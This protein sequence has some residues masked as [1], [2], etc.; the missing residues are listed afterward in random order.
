MIKLKCFILQTELN[1]FLLT[2][3][4]TFILKI[5]GCLM[6]Y[7]VGWFAQSRPWFQRTFWTAG[8][9]KTSQKGSAHTIYLGV[10]SSH[11][12]FQHLCLDLPY[13]APSKLDAAF[14]HFWLELFWR[15]GCPLMQKYHI[16]CLTKILLLAAFMWAI[17]LWFV[18]S[19]TW[20][21]FSFASYFF[22]WGCIA[23]TW[24]RVWQC[25]ALMWMAQSLKCFKISEHCQIYCLCS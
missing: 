8:L 21:L 18:S 4:S 19:H 5:K 15:N 16:S 10:D 20:F 11:L 25:I 2:D 1:Y 3:Y 17:F 9:A 24:C 14:D 22:I 7:S 6:T 23:F 13:S 12:C